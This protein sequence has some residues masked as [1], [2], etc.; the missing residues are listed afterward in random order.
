M[1][2]DL[3]RDRVQF[4]TGDRHIAGLQD[5]QITRN[6]RGGILV[7][8][9]DHHGT[10]PGVLA[11]YDRFLY[12]GT[13]RVDHAAHT[14]PCQVLLEH[15]RRVRSGPFVIDALGGGEH[16]QRLIRHGLVLLQDLL[17]LFP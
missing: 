16:T 17:P 11:L 8:P 15:I 2:K 12:L 14:D 10:D 7:V 3:V 13:D 9:G 5:P 1:C 4:R 6:R